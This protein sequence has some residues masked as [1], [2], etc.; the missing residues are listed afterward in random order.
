MDTLLKSKKRM[1]KGPKPG[2]SGLVSDN[3]SVAS[4]KLIH[5]E[6]IRIENTYQLQPDEGKRFK[7]Y[8][9]EEE[10]KRILRTTLESPKYKDSIGSSLT[11]DLANDIRRAIQELGWPR[12]KYVVQ[13]VLGQNKNQAVQMGSRCL[14]D[15][16]C[17]SFACASYSNRTIF[18]VAACFGVYFD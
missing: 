4:D 14:W 1:G 10:M 8:I 18:A 15:Q 11:T 9:V 17:D 5:H 3:Y 2:K 16:H 6:G 7:S 12:Y 13:V